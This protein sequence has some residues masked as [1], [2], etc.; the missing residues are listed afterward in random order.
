MEIV[1]GLNRLPGIQGV[2][3]FIW[4]PRRE[5]RGVGEPILFDCGW[6]WSGPGLVPS[7]IALGCEPGDLRTIAITHADIDHAGRLAS[8][9]AVSN[10]TIVAHELE[11][12]RLARDAWRTLPGSAG[13]VDPFST[14]VGLLYRRWP[15]HPVTVTRR[16]R[17]GDAI[18]GGWITV[19]TPGH[20]PGHAS[21]FN[22]GLKTLIAGDALGHWGGRF[23]FYEYGRLRFPLS[24]YCEDPQAA[25]QSLRKLANLEPDVICFGHGTELYGAATTLRRFVESLRDE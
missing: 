6:S 20:T 24:A 10:A 22:A 3:A 4:H 1:P 13:R 2:N 7:L 12:P 17:D 8:L 15:P 23:S 18:G 14:G 25:A 16:V 11:A 19:H 5:Q 21:F 9:R